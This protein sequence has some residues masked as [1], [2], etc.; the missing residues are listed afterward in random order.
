MHVVIVHDAVSLAEGPDAMDVIVQADA[1]AQALSEMGH[2]SSR[3]AC[4]LNLDAVAVELR[5]RRADLVFNLVESIGGR[6]RLIHLLPFCLDA[7]AMPYTGACAEAMLLTSNKL[8]AKQWMAAAGIPTPAWIGLSSGISHGVHVGEGNDG[9][10][11]WIIKSVWEHASIGLDENSIL[12]ERH[13]E[14]VFAELR[15]RAP[16]LGGSCFAERFIEGREF[17][18]SLIAGPDG[19]HILPPAEILFEGYTEEMPRIVDYRAKWDEGAYGY[20]HTPR[21]FEFS[22]SDRDLLERLKALA[23]RCWDHF[24][25]NG[26]ARVD[27]RVDDTG[28]PWVLEIN[29]NPCLSPDAGFAAALGQAGIAYA[30]AVD[31]IM[32]DSGLRDPS[33]RGI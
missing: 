7:L 1:V 14:T 19:P 28:R 9:G 6:G 15:D 17:N 30:D 22:F 11:I 4:T 32:A 3:I 31:R 27:F 13:T 26:Y 20:H 5:R 2:A 33:G 23:L 24:R 10:D 16:L 8:L 18:L 25:L 29:A 12:R 21:R